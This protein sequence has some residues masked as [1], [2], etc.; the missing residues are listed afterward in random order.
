LQHLSPLSL[1][2]I[3][4]AAYGIGLSKTGIAGVGI[5]A[6]ALFSVA[7]PGRAA[8]GA[9]LPLLV[10]ADCFA[11]LYYRRSAVWSHLIRLFPWAALGIVIGAVAM[12]KISDHHVGQ[13][14]GALLIA[15]TA[16]QAYQKAKTQK[17]VSAGKEPEVGFL[18]SGGVA[19]ASLGLLAGFATMVGN[20]AG[21]L[22]ILYLLAARLPKEEFVGTGA[23]YFFCLNIFKIPFSLHLG[24][25]TQQTL[26]IDLQLAIFVVIGAI[27][28]RP[29]LKRINQDLFENLS[30]LFT[31]IAAVKLMFFTR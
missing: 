8:V 21:P 3:I 18:A 29:I 19:S 2:L 24:N 31:A 1:A 22:M 12:G 30:M 14:V 16:L 28:G 27:S 20:A 23:W 4:L 9:V 15:L 10:L 17:A 6:V 26:G 13:L 7:M 5:V 25:I 11:V